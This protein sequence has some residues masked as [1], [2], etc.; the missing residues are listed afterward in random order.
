MPW[1]DADS[2]LSRAWGPYLSTIIITLIITLTVPIVLH[3]FLYKSRTITTTPTF[4]VV[5]PSGSGKT[6]L[7][8]KL[9]RGTAAST[10]TSQV[11]LTVKANLPN[12]V[13][14]SSAK[15]RSANDFEAKQPKSVFLQ[16]TPGHGKLRYHAFSSISALASSKSASARNVIFVVDAA[17]LSAA[18]AGLREAAEY[19]YDVLLSLQ[20]AYE[21]ASTSK[22]RE[23]HFLIAANKMDLFTALP[24]DVVK[25][26][27]ERE[28]SSL[29]ETKARG[30]SAVSTVGNGEGLGGE[31]EE[32]EDRSILGGMAEG[33]FKFAGMQ[34]YDVHVDVVGG[35]VVGEEGPGVDGWWE[36]I[37]QQM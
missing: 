30:I 36:W 2:W 6:A 9:E 28:L 16:D 34:E 20:K 21:N 27:L 11:P 7:V 14:P 19:L 13:T 1:Y 18:S 5:G 29:R 26:S 25:R 15:Y 8:T 12:S 37:A 32:E 31:A 23:V 35:N 33:D 3:L 17:D 10:H 4:L 22:S 24:T